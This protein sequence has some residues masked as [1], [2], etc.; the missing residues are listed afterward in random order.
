[1]NQDSSIENNL[2]SDT[3]L[4]LISTLPE[5]FRS[6]FEEVYDG[7]EEASPE[8]IAFLSSLN[9][10]AFILT[11]ITELCPEGATEDQIL[12]T[13]SSF[14]DGL[15][16]YNSFVSARVSTWSFAIK[17]ILGVFEEIE[18]HELSKNIANC[19]S[20]EMLIKHLSPKAKS[21]TQAIENY[22]F[23]FFDPEQ[24]TYFF[25][26]IKSIFACQFAGL[27]EQAN[28]FTEQLMAEIFNY[29]NQTVQRLKTKILKQQGH[30]EKSSQAGKSGRNNRYE[31]SDKV[32]AFAIKLFNEGK[33]KN[34]HQASL[35]IVAKVSKYGESIGYRFTSSYQA[36]R[37]I[38]TWI[39]K[40]KKENSQ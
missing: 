39:R 12:E 25:K 38:G 14:P 15:E 24:K 33:F 37:T 34:P 6:E 16:L 40:H 35:A 23:G 10:H 18:N 7:D 11:R 30:K 4:N 20:F 21:N 22:F 31:K 13:L 1:M 27:T 2:D 28:L 32:K 9:E 8:F 36:P 19:D 17:G 5:E 29:K 3:E 26:L